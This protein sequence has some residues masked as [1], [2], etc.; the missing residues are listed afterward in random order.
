[1]VQGFTGADTFF[2]AGTL[3]N[4]QITNGLTILSVTPTTILA[5]LTHADASSSTT[6]TIIQQGNSTTPCA[7][8]STI[9]S[10][11]NL[12]TPESQPIQ[13]DQLGN[14]NAFTVPGLY[15]VQFYAAGLTTTIKQIYGGTSNVPCVTT[16]LAIQFNNAG[17]FGCE[18]DLTFTA[19]HTLAL[20][21]GGTFNIAGTANFSGTDNFSGP[22]T[23]TGSGNTGSLSLGAT[24][25]GNTSP[26]T[27]LQTFNAGLTSL[28]QTDA[29]G[30]IFMAVPSGDI[31]TAINSAYAALGSSGGRI[32]LPPGTYSYSTPIVLSTTGKSVTVEGNNT[33]ATVLLYTPSTGT[34]LTLGASYSSLE[35]F[36][37]ETT[38]AGSTATGL[39]VLSSADS[40]RE[41]RF[42]ISGFAIDTNDGAYSLSVLQSTINSCSTAAGSIGFETTGTAD[43]THIVSS[44]FRSGCATLLKLGN[45]NPL[46]GSG[47]TLSNATSLWV[48]VGT[49]H[50]Y[51]TQCHWFNAS[52]TANWFSN[53]GGVVQI[54]DS[55]FEDDSA[56]GSSASYAT[57]SSG[58]LA[59]SDSTLYSG[60][61]TVTQ[62]VNVTGGDAQLTNILNNSPTQIPSL[63]GFYPDSS[64]RAVV[65][66]ANGLSAGT[67]TLSG[68]AGSHTFSVAYSTAPVCTANDTT[69]ANAVKVSS[70]TTA[71]TLAGTT[72]DVIAWSCSPSAN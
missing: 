63:N 2:N 13:T 41:V 27:G 39:S 71:V 55:Q 23:F 34:A 68:G 4:G 33:V 19:P 14:W 66:G 28:G 17:A 51:C 57:Q 32:V 60:G 31:G 67:I 37:L 70:S 3:S 16:A 54:N 7:P 20:G 5:N 12:T 35:H 18:P 24:A 42:N 25:L 45:A 53:A 36:S 44:E 11:V 47:L 9:Y 62:F 52:A 15:Y 46:W 38:T 21:A 40:S 29:D 10:D 8:E 59:M 30:T 61:H 72:T 64:A 43:E 22:V 49:G 6:G 58:F 69:A 26:W 1:M 65:T 50:L 56:T 48:D